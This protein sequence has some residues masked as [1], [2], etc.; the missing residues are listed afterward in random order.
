MGSRSS[1]TKWCNRSPA[2]PT[3]SLWKGEKIKKVIQHNHEKGF[4]QHE[5]S[6]S[7][8]PCKQQ[9][10]TA[11]LRGD[12]RILLTVPRSRCQQI[13]ANRLPTYLHR[14]RAECQSR[15]PSTSKLWTKICQGRVLL[16]P[17]TVISC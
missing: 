2:K 5:P 8:K 12:R 13:L 9:T 1:A 15:L 17:G 6:P 10:S 7:I 14:A 4:W 3:K 11:I 16:L